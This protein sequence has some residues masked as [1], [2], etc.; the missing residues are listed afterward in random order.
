M[1]LEL[2]TLDQLS[3]SDMPLTIIRGLFDDQSHFYR[4]II[5]MLQAGEVRL[6]ETDGND[7]A[8]WRWREI[9]TTFDQ[10]E[11]NSIRIAITDIGGQRIG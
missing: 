9:L 3:G 7:I 6:F 10:S 5:A 11:W 2:E 4:A 8:Q 1:C